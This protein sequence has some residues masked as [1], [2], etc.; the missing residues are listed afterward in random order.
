[1]ETTE[2]THLLDY[3]VSGMRKAADEL[4]KLQLQA[5]LGKM[6]A[7]DAYE[8]IKKKYKNITHEMKLRAENGMEQLQDLQAKFQ[9][10]QV[11]LD[12]GKAETIEAFEEQRKK[13][14][15]AI[16]E[17]KVTITTNPN[18]IKAY[19]FLLEALE[20]MKAQLDLI[21]EQLSPVGE[22]INSNLSARKEEIEKVIASFKEKFNDRTDFESRME[23]F[24]EE[25]TK[26]YSH[27]RK[28]FVQ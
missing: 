9:D 5:G 10:F 14:L 6:E 2:N 8:E 25:M 18:Y 17:I 7:L 19:A 1:M 22:K 20:K 21:G 16:H 13:I 24:Q 12:L 4:E 28:A 3:V 23:T 11:Q 26:A 15:L 27:L